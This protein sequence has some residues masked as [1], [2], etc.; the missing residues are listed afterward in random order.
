MADEVGP[1]SQKKNIVVG[2]PV[3][4]S[5]PQSPYPIKNEDGQL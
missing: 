2:D 3:F 4:C 5:Q 1:K